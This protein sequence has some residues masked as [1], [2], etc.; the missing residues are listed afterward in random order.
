MHTEHFEGCNRRYEKPKEWTDEQ[1]EGVDAMEF[2]NQETGGQIIRT[3]WKPN[4]D[5]LKAINEGRGIVLD[6]HIPFMV[7]VAVFT[8][9]ENGNINE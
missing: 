3:L 5:D 4:V 6:L 8:I 2:T 9:D 1:C 7:P